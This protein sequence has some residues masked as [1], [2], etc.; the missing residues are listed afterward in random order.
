MVHTSGDPSAL[1][2]PLRTAV[3]TLEPNMPVFGVRSMEDFYRASSSAASD[4][5][6]RLV[7]GTGSIGLLL[8]VIGLYGLIAYSVSRRTR[9][10]GIRMAVGAQ[11]GAVLRMVMRQGLLLAGSGTVIGVVA[12]T[13]AGGLLRSAFPFPNIAAVDAVTYLMVVPALLCVTLLAA[14]VPARRAA[15]IDPLRALRME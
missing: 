6:V 8:A 14:Y 4:L 3:R 10:I 12:S 7:A 9:E 2:D 13:A 15:R 11:S 1:A 5:L